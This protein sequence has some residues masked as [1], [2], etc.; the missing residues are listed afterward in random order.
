MNY[1]GWYAIKPN[2]PNQTLKCFL[3][4][5]FFSTVTFRKIPGTA[6]NIHNKLHVLQSKAD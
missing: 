3:N 2:K 5:Y 4:S 1:K 6:K